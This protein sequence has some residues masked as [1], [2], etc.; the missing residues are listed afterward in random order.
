M[1]IDEIDN[2]DQHIA[3]F[4][5]KVAKSD[6]CWLWT[7]AINKGT[8]YG[9]YTIKRLGQSHTMDAHRFAYFVTY[10][11][12][13]NDLQ[14]CHSCDINYP[15]KDITYRKCVRPDHLWLGT[16]RDNIR[17]AFAKGRMPQAEYWRLHPEVISTFQ[18]HR[19]CGESHK[20]AK[21]TQAQ[22][23]E[24]LRRYAAGETQVALARAYGVVQPHI[25]RIVR[26][27]NWAKGNGRYR[28]KPRCSTMEK[29]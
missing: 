17:D 12:I 19:Y 13:P 15:V 22:V 5:A 29:Q 2:L 1:T 9:H 4:W 23:D 14:V 11:E 25:S 21:L 8:G 3:R 28:M 20:Q 16:T 24:I 18:W 10:G 6:T 27:E 26:R 7:A